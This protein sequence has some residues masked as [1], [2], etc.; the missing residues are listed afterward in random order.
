MLTCL[1]SMLCLMLLTQT[2]ELSVSQRLDELNNADFTIRESA[3]QQMM[4]SQDLSATE[5]DTL[6][7][8]AQTPEQKH[9]ICQI[10]LHHCLRDWIKA[11]KDLPPAGSI[12]IR[13]H[14]IKQSEDHTRPAGIVVD[15]TLPGF[16][17]H[18]HLQAGDLIIAINNTDLNTKDIKLN[19]SNVLTTIIKQHRPGQTVKLTILRVGQTLPIQFPVAPADCLGK[20][21]DQKMIMERSTIRLTP[22]AAKLWQNRLQSLQGP[23]APTP[24]NPKIQLQ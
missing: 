12:G 13:L 17:A 11:Q 1:Q 8:L 2:G 24:Q 15:A 10:A 9:R 19:L 14:A 18:E 7:Q 5:L 6:Y 22:F 3:T 16:P 23:I 20:L 4:Q 21:Y